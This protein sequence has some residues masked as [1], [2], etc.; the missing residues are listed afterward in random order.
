[1]KC[2]GQDSRYWK[3]DDIFETKCPKCETLIEFFRDDSHR[4]CP[5]CK[6][7]VRNPNKTLACAKWCKFGRQCLLEGKE[8]HLK[9]DDKKEE[10]DVK[11]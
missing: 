4:T 10:D 11:E 6:T 7:K 8:L 9:D 5:N 3:P 2:P 1:M